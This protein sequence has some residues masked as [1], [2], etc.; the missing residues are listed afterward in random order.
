MLLP[1]LR[2]PYL[3]NEVLAKELWKELTANCSVYTA[4][5]MG[6]QRRMGSPASHNEKRPPMYLPP[7][8][9]LQGRCPGCGPSAHLCGLSGSP[10]PSQA[11]TPSR[12]QWHSQHC[13]PVE[14]EAGR[15]SVPTGPCRLIPCNDTP[16]A[17]DG[18]RSRRTLSTLTPSGGHMEQLGDPRAQAHLCASYLPYAH[19]SIGH[20]DQHDDQGL[21]KGCCGLFALLK[22]GQDLRSQSW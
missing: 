11:H 9:C 3:S 22:A 20:K 14:H 19:D 13:V 15:W 21:H 5:K 18:A 4:R 17:W 12:P 1:H 10:C 16:G 6:A 7:P 2:S 8:R